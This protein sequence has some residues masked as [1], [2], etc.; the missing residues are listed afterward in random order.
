MK[1]YYLDD[2]GLIR[3]L[4][5]LSQ[6]INQNTASTINVVNVENQQT[7]E[8]IQEVENPNKFAT[9]GAVYNYVKNQ[10]NKN[11]TIV[12]E[13]AVEDSE[14]SFNVQTNISEYNG[15]NAAQINL[16]LVDNSDIRRLFI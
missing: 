10:S 13:Y 4:Q 3:T 14:N 2:Q 1:K 7:G 5:K 16:N 6:T 11:L 8:I 9:V 12:K 15:S